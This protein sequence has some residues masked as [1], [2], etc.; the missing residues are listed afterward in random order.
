MWHRCR[1]IM[2]SYFIQF[3]L[4]FPSQRLLS[5]KVLSGKLYNGHRSHRC[6]HSI[7]RPQPEMVQQQTVCP[8][9]LRIL[10]CSETVVH[11]KP[12]Y[13]QLL[14][15][16]SVIIR[17]IYYL[18]SSKPKNLISL[19][20]LLHLQIPTT[21]IQYIHSRPFRNGWSTSITLLAQDSL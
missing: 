7:R 19:G 1:D 21:E 3:K 8:S 11:S 16:P 5:S 6:L 4:S 20:L 12:Y 15:F 2:L 17:H 10:S 14:D 9:Y 18:A 13:P